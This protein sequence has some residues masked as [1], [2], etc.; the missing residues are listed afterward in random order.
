MNLPHHGLPRGS[1]L[2][3]VGRKSHAVVM[4]RKASAAL[5]YQLAAPHRPPRRRGVNPNG[6]IASG[7]PSPNL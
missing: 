7:L 5:S 4:K 2:A 1:I 3:T 6:G